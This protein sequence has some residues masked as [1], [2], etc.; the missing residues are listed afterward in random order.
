MQR[1]TLGMVVAALVAAGCSSG[2][3]GDGG[4]D[5]AGIGGN[6]T[7]SVP[8]TGASAGTGAQSGIG[9]NSTP[10]TG[11]APGAGGGPPGSGGEPGV[12][13][14][15]VPGVPVTSQVSRLTNSQY[16]RAVR[17]LLGVTALT[18]QNNVAP[19][20]LLAPDQLGS[21]DTQTWS[22]YQNVGSLVA[23]QVMADPALKGKFLSCATTTLECIT[24]SIDT[25]GRKAFRRPLTA[26]EK[27]RFGKLV[28]DGASI[29][30]TGTPDEVA[31][32][33]LTGFLI[34]PSFLTRA[35]VEEAVPE[36]GGFALSSHEIASRLAFMLTGTIPDP[37][38]SKAADDGVLKT[39]EQILAQAKRLIGTS[40]AHE[41]V[42]A[43]HQSYLGADNPTSRWQQAAGTGKDPK[44]AGFT[45]ELVPTLGEEEKKLFDYV[46][47][48]Q[49]GSFKD[50]LLTDV[51]FVTDKTAPL[52]GLTGAFTSTLT[53]AKL[54]PSRPGFLTRLGFL[55]NFAD[56]GRSNPILR[57]AFVSKDVMGVDPGNPVPG[58]AMT[59]LP[60]ASADL[61]TN[62]KR[63]EAMTGEG[64]C[65]ECHVP[66][67]NPPGFALESFD[68]IGVLQATEGPGGPAIDTVVDITVDK[69]LPTV[70]VNNAA[71]MMAQIAASP[72][73]HRYYATKMVSF[74]YERS[75]N[76]GD[77]CVAQTLG[78]DLQGG[79]TIKD[80][81]AKLATTDTFRLRMVGPIEV[82]P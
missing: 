1:S 33:V 67:V 73:A 4:G 5:G 16:D 59:K 9:G 36:A 30:A 55:A 45:K 27:A 58:A 40:A 3:G 31:Q 75:P 50:L 18:T 34:S 7:G 53:Q 81:F 37:E 23:A 64:T 77:A 14:S 17:D 28:T 54:D 29:T 19:S 66:Y 74:G 78:T 41:A 44:F 65:G 11:S 62:R 63:V 56:Y 76:P 52:Y 6:G 15:C 32:V 2:G 47:F 49:G 46:T 82:K 61:N 39:T 69:E 72:L 60:E 24:S 71:E 13:P 38:L 42:E 48:E 10:G 57:G 80:T 79:A 25:F 43:F 12:L 21:V 51:A 20:G 35:E 22:A 70:R 8:G 26:D 68:A